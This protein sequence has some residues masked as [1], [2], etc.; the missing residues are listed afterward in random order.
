MRG[1]VDDGDPAT[2]H[3]HATKVV[4]VID[5]TP[6]ETMTTSATRDGL[7]EDAV[8]DQLR[9]PYEIMD[10]VLVDGDD[11]IIWERTSNFVADA[12]WDRNPA[13]EWT[14]K[15]ALMGAEDNMEDLDTDDLNNLPE[16]GGDIWSHYFQVEQDLAG[17]RTLHL[18]LRSDFNPNAM[19]LGDALMIAR[20]PPS[21]GV[22]DQVRVRWDM[23]TMD[24]GDVAID[25]ERNLPEDADTTD[26]VE[27]IPGSYMGVKGI[28]YCV[29]GEGGTDEVNICR[30]NRHSEDWM[31]V[32]EDDEVAFR[33]Y[34]YTDDTDWLAAGVWLTI[35]DDTEDGDY[36]IGSFVFGNNP[37]RLR[38]QTT[39]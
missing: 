37:T 7:A 4:Q 39:P 36:A 26:V 8:V 22:D 23:V 14:T 16:T 24:G 30:I 11:N 27:G 31:A 10:P 32:S 35:P 13:A 25:G 17:G 19:V 1:G 29:E 34:T 6:T 9:D 38:R 5:A 28:F 12:D 33:P 18:D 2:E 15:P 20:G 3:P 21:T